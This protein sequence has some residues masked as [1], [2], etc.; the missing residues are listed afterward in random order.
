MQSVQNVERQYMKKKL[1]PFRVGD[2]VKVHVRVVEGNRERTQVYQGIV[3]GRSGA[4]IK[5]TFTVRKIS[6]GVGVE[7]IFPVHSPRVEK[8]E[9]I[10]RGHV[11]RAKLY[12]LRGRIGRK[13]TRLRE[14][15]H[16][17]IDEEMLEVLP[18]DILTPEVEELSSDEELMVEESP[19]ESEE[20]SDSEPVEETGETSEPVTEQSTDEEHLATEAM[21]AET[22][23]PEAEIRP[24][25]EETADSESTDSPVEK[26]EQ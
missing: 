14:K 26:D 6:F 25:S 2:T 18:E 17:R 22:T 16:V 9:I 8:V 12:F 13:A 4:G 7:R 15:Y 20:S 3:I 19:I 21:P 10:S 24:E 1:P 23:E 5:E 11:R